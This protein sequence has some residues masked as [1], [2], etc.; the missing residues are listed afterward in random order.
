MDGFARQ[1]L[2]HALFHPFVVVAISGIATLIFVI[3]MLLFPRFAGGGRFYLFYYHA[4]IAFAFVTYLFDR[5]E[6]WRKI[7][8][9]QWPIELSVLGLAISRTLMPIP[10]ISGH[11]FHNE[12][13]EPVLKALKA[14]FQS[15]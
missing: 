7:R 15:Y 5:A 14:F 6:Q 8:L 10:F 12:R 2:R 1:P 11:V 9:R 13:K 4:P 3:A